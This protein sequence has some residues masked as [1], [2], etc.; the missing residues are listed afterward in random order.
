MDI[1]DAGTRTEIEQL[2]FEHS[3]RMDH[4]HADQVW[5]L[6]TEDAVSE[7]P[8]GT[9]VGRQA[10]KEW[11][12]RRVTIAAGLVRHVFGGMRLAWVGSVLC[13]TTY[14]MAFRDSSPDPLVPA[15]MG[16]FQDEYAQVDGRWRIRKR[17]V[18]PILGT[19]NAAAHAQRVGGAADV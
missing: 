17:T 19:A 9:M 4:G 13:G 18:V 12:A 8:M 2:V 10:I 7:G 11:G 1:I 5:E 3:W 14:Y 15:S 16:E 6:F